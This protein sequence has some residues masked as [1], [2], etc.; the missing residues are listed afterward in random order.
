MKFTL[1]INL[2]NAD[3]EDAGID[4]VLPGYLHQVSMRVRNGHGDAGT[5]LDD[6]GNSI[7]RYVT[8]D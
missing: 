3:V 7:G 6:N 2:D 4:I 5:V 1:E 8:T